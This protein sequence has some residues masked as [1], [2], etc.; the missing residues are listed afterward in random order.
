[1][2]AR[3]PAVEQPQELFLLRGDVRGDLLARIQKFSSRIERGTSE[4]FQSLART[5]HDELAP[6]GL[7]LGL[8]ANDIHELLQQLSRAHDKIAD[9][10]CHQIRD[11]GGIYFTD[12]PLYEPGN[13]ALLFPGEGAQ[14]PGML[15][16]LAERFDCVANVLSRCEQLATTAEGPG[17]EFVSFLFDDPAQ[18]SNTDFDASQFHIAMFTVLVANMAMNQLLDH[19]QIPYDAVAGHSAGEFSAIPAS[20]ALTNE[21]DLM[22]M[23][24][25]IN[26]MP[27]YTGSA[28]ALL[29]I[30]KSREQVVELLDSLELP[31]TP[32][33]EL[34]AHVAMDNCPHQTIVVGLPA[35]I[36]LI[37]NE[38]KKRMLIHERLEL[39]RPY[40][41]P[42]F[43]PF[44]APLRELCEQTQ[45]ESPVRRVYSATTAQQFPGDPDQL[46]ELVVQHWVSTVE[47]SRLVK[48][49]YADGHRIFIDVGGGMLGAF[50]E[51]ILRG[52]PCLVVAANS[53]RWSAMTQ[54]LHLLAQLAVHQ[55]PFSGHALRGDTSIPPDT[56]VASIQSDASPM[57]SNSVMDRY[58]NVMHRFLDTQQRVMQSYL[59]T[60]SSGGLRRR[61]VRRARRGPP[62]ESLPRARA[63]VSEHLASSSR[64][65]TP[66]PAHS[67][68]A[69]P[70]SAPATFPSTDAYPL[71]DRVIAF[72]PG[73]S[74]TVRRALDFAEDLYADHHTVGG[75]KISAVDPRQHGLPVAP[76]TF[77]LETM[78]EIATLLVPGLTVRAIQNVQL[79]RWLAF[80]E[81]DPCTAEIRSTLR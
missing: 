64:P 18:Q 77:T 28:A 44:I 16:G 42:L 70:L 20:G 56:K 37:E 1:M 5:T 81:N 52:E 53:K 15:Y 54:L 43:K 35:S 72:A 75:Q 38:L 3:L 10:K 58:Q 41:T 57:T 36:E 46:R 7:R 65:L 80:Y 47:F 48:Q 8:V 9:P 45:F 68:P 27:H 73:Q 33:G 17:H 31:L 62:Q 39:D 6:G 34:T 55:V 24:E 21:D 69:R 66:S 51:D 4:T 32:S 60:R 13:L 79:Y 11:L 22:G 74:V 76:M 59:Q 2:D 63:P 50:S 12:A 40:H 49:M 29:A 26:N 78:A 71:L 25:G 14:F 19:L 23:L 61:G 30:G 67:P